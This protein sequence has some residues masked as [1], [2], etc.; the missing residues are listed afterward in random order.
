MSMDD[1]NRELI[2]FLKNMQT[3]N[4]KMS[5]DWDSLQVA[6]RDADAL[7]NDDETRTR[8]DHD[9]KEMGD[10]LQR[11]RSKESK[12]YEEFLVSRKRALDRY[13]GRR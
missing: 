7:W 2:N 9:W 4:L 6:W 12:E 10:A 13:Y 3:F 8:F 11:Y 5:Q 1:L